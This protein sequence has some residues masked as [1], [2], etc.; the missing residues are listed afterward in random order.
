MDIIIRLKEESPLLALL[1]KF[2]SG[3]LFSEIL[4]IVR[5]PVSYCVLVGFLRI[6]LQCFSWL[7]PSEGMPYIFLLSCF[8]WN[9]SFLDLFVLLSLCLSSLVCGPFAY[10]KWCTLFSLLPYSFEHFN[11]ETWGSTRWEARACQDS[12]EEHDY[13][14]WDD[15][16]CHWD[17][18]WEDIQSDRGQA[19]DDWPLSG[20]VLNIIQACQAWKTRY[21]CY[22]LIKVHSSEVIWDVR[23]S[24]AVFCYNFDVGLRLWKI[25]FGIGVVSW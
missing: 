22:S 9:D 8:N 25:K 13:C 11:A 24:R 1:L 15:W 20:W 19:W 16:E 7:L 12:S 23:L 5:N 18:Q 4:C 14:S 3:W 10:I 2:C 6:C 17:L 21:W